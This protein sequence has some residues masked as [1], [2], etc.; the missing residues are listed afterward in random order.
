MSEAPDERPPVSESSAKRPAALVQTAAPLSLSGRMARRFHRAW[1]RIRPIPVPQYST[2]TPQIGGQFD[3]GLIQSVNLQTIREA[4]MSEEAHVFLT[5]LLQR[6]TPERDIEAQHAY[7]ELSQAQFG[8]HWQYADLAHVLWAASTLIKP[9]SYLEIGVMRGRSAAIIGGVSPDC[10]ISGF[11]MWVE[12]YAGVPIPGPD[13]VRSELQSMGHR[14]NVTLVSGDS[15]KTV[16]AY[17]SE[18]PDLYFDIILVDGGKSVLGVA[19]DY[20]N[21]LPRLKVGGIVMTDDLALYPTLRRVWRNFIQRDS[22]Y[23]AHEIFDV[24]YSVAVAIRVS[25]EPLF[26]VLARAP[27]APPNW[28]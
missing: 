9:A 16:A 25:D 8:K 15:G 6:L 27:D 10:A 14:A 22:R 4:A 1:D 23:M 28:L 17:L 20:A 18:H 21:V 7:Y 2:G 24:G 19:T 3:P 12:D 13:F 26:K 5:D 11:D